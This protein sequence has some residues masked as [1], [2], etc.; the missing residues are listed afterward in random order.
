[1]PVVPSFQNVRYGPNPLHLE[2]GGT[3]YYKFDVAFAGGTPPATFDYSVR[4]KDASGKVVKTMTGTQATNGQ[5]TV[6]VQ[7]HAAMTADGGGS[8]GQ[9]SW[10]NEFQASSTDP[11]VQTAT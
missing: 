7:I 3:M 9:G 1:M 6:A 11:D 5:S 8:L 2:Q 10:T 4:M